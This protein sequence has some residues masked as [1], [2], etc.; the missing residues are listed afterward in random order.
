MRGTNI[1]FSVVIFLSVITSSNC[2]TSGSKGKFFTHD[3]YYLKKLQN[4]IF[5]FRSCRIKLEVWN[6][7]LTSVYNASGFFQWYDIFWI[8]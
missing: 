4:Q 5:F 6:W 2:G 3:H 1:C 7:G 8:V